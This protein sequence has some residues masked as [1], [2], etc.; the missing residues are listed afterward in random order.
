MKAIVLSDS[1]HFF[2][3]IM[4]IVEREKQDTIDLV[5]HAGDVYRDVEDMM[6]AYPAL[7]Y[8][9]V[10]GN[11]DFSVVGVPFNRLFSFDGYKIFLTHGHNYGVKQSLHRLIAQGKKVGAKVCIFG[12]THKPYLEEKDGMWLLNPGASPYSYAVIETG[13]EKLNIVIKER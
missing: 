6:A 4:D 9:Y 12:H 2:S 8:E 5:I 10:L 11:N 1:H 3:S 13:G 7:R